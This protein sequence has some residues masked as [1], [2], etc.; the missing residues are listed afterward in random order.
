MDTQ[1]QKSYN[2][3]LIGDS[4]T[5]VY[6]FGEC[7]R[8][9]PEAPVPVFTKISKEYRDGMASN[10]HNNL[11]NMLACNLRFITNDKASIKKIRFVDLKSNQHI[12]RYDIEKSLDP[13][14]IS[15]VIDEASYDAIVISDYNKGFIDATLVKELRS[16]YTCPIFVDT[17]KS[18][19]D[20][21]KDCIVKIN[22]HEAATA[23]SID[24]V[25]LIVTKGALGATYRGKLYK[26]NTVQVN[27]VCGAG[28]VFLAALVTSWLETQD[29]SISINHANACAGY[30][31]N[32][33]GTYYLSRR[34]YEDLRV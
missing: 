8:I 32:K 24:N 27:D 14:D 18:D 21:F 5:D 10:V 19:L 15:D 31:V 34:E 11:K 26:A 17:K 25:D 33:A 3:L 22:E 9:S 16:Q 13:L 29:M 4:C 6:V 7:R 30:S 20:I 12:M 23:T 1:Q 2:V 28:D